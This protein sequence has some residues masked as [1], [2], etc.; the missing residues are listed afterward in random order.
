MV[1]LPPNQ[2]FW[3]QA[4]FF[5]TTDYCYLHCTSA[6]HSYC[7]KIKHISHGNPECHKSLLRQTSA[8]AALKQPKQ[9]QQQLQNLN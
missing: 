1:M 5:K 9:L 2:T 8:M 7:T 3:E 4:I 6:A